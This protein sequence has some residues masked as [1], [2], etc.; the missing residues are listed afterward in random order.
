MTFIEI[1]SESR[2]DDFAREVYGYVP[3]FVQ[4]FF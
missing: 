4:L 1:Y 2:F 3:N